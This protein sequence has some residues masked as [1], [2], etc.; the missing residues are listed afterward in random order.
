MRYELGGYEWTAIKPMLPNS[1]G[2]RRVNN[3]RVL[4]GIFWVPRSG[5]PWRDLPE[6]Y[7]PRTTCYNRFVRWRRAGVW[8]RIMDALAAGRDAAMQMIDTRI[9]CTAHG[10][11]LHSD[12]CFSQ[13]L[14]RGSRGLRQL[15]L[16]HI[17]LLAAISAKNI[18]K[19]PKNQVPSCRIVSTCM[20][21]TIVRFAQKIVSQCNAIFRAE[22]AWR[23]KSHRADPELPISVKL[24]T[25]K[26]H[27]RSL[28]PTH[29]G[30]VTA[31][32]TQVLRTWTL[33]IGF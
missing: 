33:E 16:S 6:N 28:S 27:L 29:G 25:A 24:R 4:N 30:S 5:A 7:G 12:V 32:A 13:S 17:A 26:G 1:R 10:A 20:F 2:V 23:V 22:T 9:Q 3:R 18:S 19:R 31:R 11:D 15:R 8:D 14:A 21:P